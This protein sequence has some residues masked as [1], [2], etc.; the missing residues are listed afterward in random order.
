MRIATDV[1]NAKGFSARLSGA[2]M[3]SNTMRPKSANWSA[4]T[5][6]RKAT[7]QDVTRIFLANSARTATV[8]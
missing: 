5:A 3:Y 4:Q 8:L 2:K 7:P 1:P 6:S